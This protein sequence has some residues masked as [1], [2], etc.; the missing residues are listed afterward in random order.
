MSTKGMSTW[1]QTQVLNHINGVATFTPS[2]NVYL[3]SFSVAPTEA[4]GGT[5][6]VGGNYIRITIVNDGTKWNTAGGGA[7]DNKAAF[8]WIKNAGSDWS[9]GANQVAWGLFDDP[10]AGHLLYFGPWTVPKP[11]K[12]DDTPSVAIGDLDMS[13]AAT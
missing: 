3:A 12:V 6:A 1:L 13:I 4:G 5:E 10:V 8:A 2:A 11:V 9:A 7:T